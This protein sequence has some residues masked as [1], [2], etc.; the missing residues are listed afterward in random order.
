MNMRHNFLTIAFLAAVF[1]FFTHPFEGSGDFYH[2]VNTGKFILENHKLPQTDIWTHTAKGLP[3]VAHSWGSAVLFYFLLNQFG[4]ISITLFA[5]SMAVLT[6][7]LLYWLLRSYKIAKLPAILTISIVAPLVASRWPQRPELFEYPFVILMLLLDIKRIKYPKL[8][9]LYPLLILIWANMYGSSAIFGL[10]LLGLL[11]LKQ[12]ISDKFKIK[13]EQ[14]L[15][16]VLSLASFPLSLLNGY[17]LRTI[18]YFIFYIPKVA[19]YEG[20]WAGILRIIALIPQE[21]LVTLQYYIIMYFVYLFT[22]FSFVLLSLRAVK[23]NVFF[24]ILG[25]AIFE[26][27]LV[28]RNLPLAAILAAPIFALSLDFQKQKH[29][30]VTAI[31]ILIVIPM[32]LLSLWLNPPSLT[33]GKNLPLEQMVSFIKTNNISGRALN[34]IGFGGFITNRLYPKVLVFLDTRDELF[35]NSQSLT[36]IHDAYSLG[37]GILPLIRKYKVNLVIADYLS[38][39]LNYKDLFYS[40]DWSLV[41]LND[42]YLVFVPKDT[43]KAKN[44]TALDYLSPLSSSGAKPGREGKAS[45]YYEK[46]AAE[47]P[48]SLQN[49]LLLSSSLFALGRF[50]EVIKI[51]ESLKADKNSPVGPAMERGKNVLLADSYLE[52][53]DCEKGKQFLDKSAAPIRPILIFRNVQ[54]ES[55]PFKQLAKYYLICENNLNLAEIYLSKFTNDASVNPLE[56]AIFRIRFDNLVKN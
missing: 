18:F 44:I 35:T 47:F 53:N 54:P 2:H 34:T 1:I 48:D 37:K 49:K 14:K 7:G 13:K 52:K 36:D 3:W 15:F 23:K 4:E 16:Y 50:D 19:T 45:E 51:T 26:P 40:L 55:E 6:F 21:Q 42:R 27:F 56:K 46:L 43:A 25:L 5:A 39:G 12:L 8:S 29:F 38:D 9:L 30:W 17:G 33:A 32:F 11:I 20:E 28:F 24:L 22:F 10:G 41:F 31:P